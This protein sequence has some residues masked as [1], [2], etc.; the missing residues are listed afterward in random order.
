MNDAAEAP[1]SWA[2]GVFRIPQGCKRNACSSG[3]GEPG[4]QGLCVPPGRESHL[5]SLRNPTPNQHVV[6]A[7]KS[8]A[9][10]SVE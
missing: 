4:T 1:S 9:R 6:G 8:A 2:S 7:Q 5:I 3:A 10:V